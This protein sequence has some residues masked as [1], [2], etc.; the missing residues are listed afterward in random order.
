MAVVGAL[1]SH[2]SKIQ[3]LAELI[4]EHKG[5]DGKSKSELSVVCMQ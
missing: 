5:S 3:S 2:V 1:G 4:K